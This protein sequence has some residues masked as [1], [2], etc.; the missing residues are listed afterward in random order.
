MLLFA[1][2]KAAPEPSPAEASSPATP[3]AGDAP[4]PAA[5]PASEVAPAPAPTDT[6]PGAPAPVGGAAPAGSERT[7]A[8][9]TKSISAK[10]G[11]RFAVALPSNITIPMKWRLDPAPDAK[12]LA[13]TQEQHTD[14]PP[15]GCDG[16]T[17]Y[18]GTRL[19]TFEAKGAGKTSL[20]FALKPLTNPGG[21]S[22][23]DVTI[24]VVT[25]P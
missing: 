10:V 5:P 21:A 19:F 20:H 4:P 11:E 23:K 1:G 24:D 7:Y 9:G 15:K 18:G 16:C 22:Q 25:T 14:A 13:L 17:G 12:L 6:P 2:C 8:E 3:P